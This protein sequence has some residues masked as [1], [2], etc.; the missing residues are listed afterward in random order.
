MRAEQR[1]LAPSE[2]LVQVERDMVSKLHAHLEHVTAH[3]TENMSDA[4]K[5]M[6]ELKVRLRPKG[7]LD[8]E[9]EK[10]A[11]QHPQCT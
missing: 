7:N 5:K 6:H 11:R 4:L 8:R 9:S 2:R 10:S 1:T 3:E